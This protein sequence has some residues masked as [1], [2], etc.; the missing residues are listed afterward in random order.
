[1]NWMN[2]YRINE[3]ESLRVS[4]W[5]D[6]A[7]FFRDRRTRSPGQPTNSR[8]MN[9]TPDRE[10]RA[11]PSPLREFTGFS[12]PGLRHLLSSA[13]QADRETREKRETFNVPYPGDSPRSQMRALLEPG[14]L[15]PDCKPLRT[16]NTHPS[17]TP[18]HHSFLRFRKWEKDF[19]KVVKGTQ[20]SQFLPRKQGQ[21]RTSNPN[22]VSCMPSSTRATSQHTR[23]D[24]LC[25]LHLP[26]LPS[27]TK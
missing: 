19:L 27:P 20:T 4:Q 15:P 25:H 5:W 22:N 8:T 23:I 21:K 1:M 9:S 10:Q 17:P 11:S 14:S 18:P 12:S 13:H 24:L 3:C 7:E 2:N 6:H 16:P 26:Q